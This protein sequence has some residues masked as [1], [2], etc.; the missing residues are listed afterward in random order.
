M[1]GMDC[2]QSYLKSQASRSRPVGERQAS[3]CRVI[4]LFSRKERFMRALYAQQI[5]SS[6]R[7]LIFN[8]EFDL[9]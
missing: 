8:F 9:I 7:N 1:R 6:L 3:L 2:C 5:V 4:L